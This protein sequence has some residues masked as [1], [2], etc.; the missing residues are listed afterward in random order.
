MTLFENFFQPK[1]GIRNLWSRENRGE[2]RKGRTEERSAG[3]TEKD[4]RTNA[5]EFVDKP[6]R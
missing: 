6:V 3:Q 1:G 2:L 4:L 5:D